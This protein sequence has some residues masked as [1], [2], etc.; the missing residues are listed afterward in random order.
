MQLGRPGRV[1]RFEAKYFWKKSAM[2]NL[3]K[4]GVYEWTPTWA[5]DTTRIVWLDLVF[6]A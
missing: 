5:G 4:A 1:S 2:T 3:A 6:K